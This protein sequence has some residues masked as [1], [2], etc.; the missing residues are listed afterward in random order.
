MQISIKARLII[1]FTLLIAASGF[2]FYLGNRN[3]NALN[4]WVTIIIKTHANRI[5]LAGK[6]SE[7]LQYITKNEKNLIIITKPEVLQETAKE[8]EERIEEMEQRLDELKG[9][10]DQQGKEDVDNFMVKWHEY[11]KIY[12]RVKTLAV[13]INTDSSN[14]AALELSN[15]IANTTANEAIAVMNKL[16]RNNEAELA[17]IDADTNQIYEEGQSNM[18]YL[19]VL[20]TIAS[21]GLSLWIIISISMSVNTAKEAI[22]ALSEGDLTIQIKQTGKDELGEL[23]EYLRVMTSKLKDV[24]SYVSTA[25]ESIASASQQIA[26]GASE[27]AASAEEVSSSM[28]QMASNIDQNTDNAQQTEKIA[29]KASED[30]REGSQAVNQ[31]VNSMKQIADKISIIGEIARQTNLLALNAAVEAARAGEHGKGFAVV[32]AEVRKL[33]ERSQ[34]AA[35]EIDVL[36]KSSVAIAERSGNVLEQIVPDIQKT[37]RLVQEISASS[38][39]QNSGAEQVNNAIQQLSQVVQSN[40]AAS[41]ELSVQAEQLREAIAFFDIGSVKH[42]NTARSTSKAKVSSHATLPKKGKSKG[43]TLDMHEHTE[44]SDA[45]YERF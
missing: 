42:H 25:S 9:L 22:K 8:G 10:V 36:S 4:S 28:E 44:V 13:V 37:S 12:G 15:G 38:M 21:V 35:I 16:V 41:E 6:L 18:T 19:L 1:A 29:Q 31:T 39:E 30:I 20:S 34:L 32:A 23:I 5:K 2:I 43:V 33:A 45:D 17:K 24:L 14:K 11:R 26:A 27:Q 40:A 7:D 3:A